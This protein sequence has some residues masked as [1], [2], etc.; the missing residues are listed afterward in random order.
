MSRRATKEQLI[1][2]Q[3]LAQQLEGKPAPV[4]MSVDEVLS[5]FAVRRWDR[6]TK[7]RVQNAF[8]LVGIDSSPRIGESERGDSII[9]RLRETDAEAVDSDVPRGARQ[10]S[11]A[12]E[13]VAPRRSLP[14]KIALWCLGAAAAAVVGNFVL[15]PLTHERLRKQ[16]GW[17]IGHKSL[18]SV[19]TSC[20][21]LNWLRPIEI[22]DASAFYQ[23]NAHVP[24]DTID[25]NRNT[26][27]TSMF[28]GNPHDVVSWG[29]GGSG[30]HRVRLV[31][32]T[33]GWTKD[34]PTHGKLGRLARI[35]VTGEHDEKRMTGKGCNRS[36]K[37]PRRDDTDLSGESIPFDCDADVLQVHIDSIHRGSGNPNE[38]AITDVRMYE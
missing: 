38:V 36:V 14:M 1:A 23:Q 5:T 37:L 31:C 29:F 24:Q 35:H 16:I 18:T 15:I 3:G 27:W 8:D 6:H 34:T 22:Q 7:A 13:G 26:A 11:P 12:A 2:A 21:D 9:V 4:A 19:P 25:G 20:R 17:A 28:R 32:L 33:N 10:G 30:D